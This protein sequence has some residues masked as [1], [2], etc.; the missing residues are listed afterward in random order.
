[1]C[2]EFQLHPYRVFHL[3]CS[4]SNT[5][6]ASFCNAEEAEFV[7]T[8]LKVM[9]KHAKPDTYSY[10]IITPYN[11]QRTEI[12]NR[13]AYV[14][15]FR[16][17]NE[18]DFPNDYF[19][20]VSFLNNRNSNELSKHKIPVN[21]IGRAF[22]ILCLHWKM[23]LCFTICKIHT[24]GRR[25]TSLYCVRQGQLASVSWQIRNA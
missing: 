9:T 18:P 1:M 23:I 11:K 5:D 15:T 2:R 14:K 16:L 24:K 3:N 4:Q 25:K 19:H 10:G 17:L 6:M 22:F 13:L 20:F 8:M 21:T 7:C 12:Q